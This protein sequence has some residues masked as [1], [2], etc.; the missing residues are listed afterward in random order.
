MGTPDFAVPALRHLAE[1]P[2]EIMAVVTQ[3]DRPRGRGR[4][5]VPSPV[6][7][8]ARGYD[9]Q[10]MQPEKVRDTGFVE[11]IRD[12]APDL[13]VVA[14]FGQILPESLL[15]IPR[16]MPINIHGSILPALR[17]AAPI[18]WAILNNLPE[19]GI[20]IMQMDKGMDT[21]D[22]LL[23]HSFPLEPDETAGTLFDKMA[24]AGADLLMTALE[25]LAEGRLEARKQPEEGV[26]FAPPLKKDMFHVNWGK[27]AVETGCLIRALDPSPGAWTQWNGQRIRIYNPVV[28]DHRPPDDI[29]CGTVTDAGEEGIFVAAAD[30]TVCIREIQY[31]G[32]RRMSCADFLRGR[33]ITP[34]D[35]FH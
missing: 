13:F 9:L 8:V 17:G 7:T 32:K 11:Q 24:K 21:G 2:D 31:P 14:A 19:T 35:I 25:R 33:S 22:I 23:Q 10:V 15:E 20:T 27:K 29:A 30:G 6:K 1:G 4:R 18:Q 5:P 26:T 34:G 3:P 28:T 12:I 16:I